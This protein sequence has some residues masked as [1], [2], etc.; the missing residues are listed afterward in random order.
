M[1]RGRLPMPGR[2]GGKSLDRDASLM[3][4][5]PVSSDSLTEISEGEHYPV[6]PDGPSNTLSIAAATRYLL[7]CPE[8]LTFR[9]ETVVT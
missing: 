9:L 8:R 7:L 5:Q 1:A 3:A 6:H 4:G 2:A